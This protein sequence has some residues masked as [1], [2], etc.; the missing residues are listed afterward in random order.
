MSLL[1]CLSS[2]STLCCSS[3]NPG[4]R[5]DISTVWPLR[6]HDITPQTPQLYSDYDTELMRVWTFQDDSM[7]VRERQTSGLKASEAKNWMQAPKYYS[8]L[9]IYSAI[10]LQYISTT[11]PASGLRG[12]IGW[13]S[14]ANSIVVKPRNPMPPNTSKRSSLHLSFKYP[15]SSS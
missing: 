15:M 5:N 3:L 10:Y 1:I 8:A 13:K 7:S 4:I 14:G 2:T 9:E 12:V 11:G 6:I